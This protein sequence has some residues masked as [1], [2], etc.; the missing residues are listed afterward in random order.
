MLLT[1][2]LAASAILVG[3]V[4]IVVPVLPGSVLILAAVVVWA[5][6]VGTTT[7]WVVLGAVTVLLAAGTV[8]KYAVPGRRLRAVGVPTRTLLA[9]GVLGVVGFFVVPVVGL[10]VGFVAGVYLSEVQRLGR[11]RAWPSTRAALHAVGL[12]VLIELAAGLLA[13][14]TW[15]VGAVVL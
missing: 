11:E 7:G 5:V 9:G 15:L 6:T 13:A 8:V 1:D 12:S 10:L 4:G 3:L 14:S 2:V